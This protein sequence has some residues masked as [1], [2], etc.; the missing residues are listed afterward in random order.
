MLPWLS[1]KTSAMPSSI[2]DRRVSGAFVRLLDSVVAAGM[3]VFI[4]CSAGASPLKSCTGLLPRS[5]AIKSCMVVVEMYG[6]VVIVGK[7]LGAFARGWQVLRD[8]SK[9]W[10]IPSIETIARD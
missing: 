4:A 6:R 1:L 9:G 10:R 8:V 7:R 2:A 5:D 3:V